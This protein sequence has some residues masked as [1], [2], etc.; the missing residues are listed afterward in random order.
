MKKS[1]LLLSSLGLVFLTGCFTGVESTPKITQREVKRQKVVD[2]PE[3][4]V[5]DSVNPIPPALWRPGKKFY[6]ADQRLARAAWRLEP[7]DSLKGRYAVLKSTTTIRTVTGD[8]EVQLNLTIEDIPGSVIEIRTGI[9]PAAWASQPSYVLPHTVD[10]DLIGAVSN[11]LTGKTYYILPARRFSADGIDTVGRRY[12]PV[13]ITSVVPES[14]A[15]PV[16]IFFTDE[17]GASSSVLMTLGNE[18]TSRR[19]FETLFAIENPRTRYKN[20]TDENWNLITRGLVTAGM[21]PEECRLAIGSPDNYVR[22]PTTAGM[23]ERWTYTNGTYLYFSD[24]ILSSYR[25]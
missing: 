7:V 25:L 8:N 19:N 20:I 2:T 11:R 10:M 22:I 13:I 5:L 4:H 21:T 3:S 14:E 23:A 16:R 12:Q 9:S 15:A 24:G 1:A 18:T 17:N 6:I